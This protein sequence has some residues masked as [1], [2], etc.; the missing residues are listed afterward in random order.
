MPIGIIGMHR[1]GTSLV[2]RLLNVAGLFLG[3]ESALLPASEF[4]EAGHWEHISFIDINERLLSAFG[5]DWSDPPL[6]PAG[7]LQLDEVRLLLAEASEFVAE[8]FSAYQPWGWKDP[9]TTLVLPFWHELLPDTRWI[10]CVRNPLDVV[11]SLRRREHVEPSHVCALW[12]AYTELALIHTRPEN[13]LIIQYEDFFSGDRPDTL[14]Q[15]LKF[16][17]LDG[18][19]D[20]E[21]TVLT[22]DAVI[23]DDLRHHA[24]SFQQVVASPDVPVPTRLLY[25][26]LV[27]R[28]E[29]L[30]SLYAVAP[31]DQPTLHI[32]PI[33]ERDALHKWQ[34]LHALVAQSTRTEHES[35]DLRLQTAEKERVVQSLREQLAEKDRIHGQAATKYEDLIAS[36]EGEVS[37]R[38]DRL[39]AV[40][41]QLQQVREEST[42]QSAVDASTIEALRRDVDHRNESV[43]ALEARIVDLER[44]AGPL[45]ARAEVLMLRLE[46][47]AK[48]H[49]SLRTQ[50]AEQEQLAHNLRQQI[51]NWQEHWS[52]VQGTIGYRVIE[53]L[54]AARRRAIPSASVPEKLWFRWMR[55]SWKG[56]PSRDALAPDHPGENMTSEAGKSGNESYTSTGSAELAY[57]GVGND[58]LYARWIEE[59]EPAEDELTRQRDLSAGFVY[60]PLISII[61]P[62]YNP[63]PE[64]LRQAIES[65]REQTYDRWEL[66]LADGASDDPRVRQVLQ[67]CANDERIH[68][69]FLERNLGISG[70]SNVA[71]AQA[72]GDFVA[73][74][75][76]D[77]TLASDALFAVVEALNRDPE[78]D[79]I[80]S[81][82]D[83]LATDGRSRRA[84]LFK[85]DWSP[86]VMLSANYITHLTVLRTALVR[87]IG[88]FDENTDGAQDWDLFLRMAERTS[89][90][91]HLPRIL[92]HWRDSVGSTAVDIA[93][94]PYALDRQLGVIERHLSRVGVIDPHAFLDDS[95]F[96]RVRWTY[97]NTSLVSIIIPSRGASPMLERCVSSILE[98]TAYPNYEIVILNNGDELSD[99]FPY[100]RAISRDARVRVVQYHE[101]FNYSA[102]NNFGARQS[103]GSL[104][105]F[106]NNDTE[107]MAPDWLDE[108]AQWASLRLPDIGVVGAKLLKPD[109]TIQHAGVV[110]GLTGF[111]GHV[112][113]GSREAQWSI[114]GLAEWYR[115]YTAVTG[116]CMM[117]RRDV[118]DSIGG[119]DE[120]FVLCGSDVDICLRLRARGYE[121]VYDPFAKLR[122]IESAT[123]LGSI[124]PSDFV[125]SH[126]RYLPLLESGD[127]FFNPSLSYWNPKPALREGEERS[128]LEF[129]REFAAGLADVV[130]SRA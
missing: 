129:V 44:S 18:V 59:N 93:A 123:H 15:L 122:H 2:A 32:H 57:V 108:L 79:L 62:V 82:H 54:R 50:L 110:V 97:D 60:R 104:L 65:V 39:R 10:I 98:H 130:E 71:L 35:R 19:L 58:D 31:S 53:K 3:D 72:H 109:G 20:D 124:P 80:Y 64:A 94:K 43:T 56:R 27:H 7:W 126:D 9:R 70:N 40:H 16:V 47:E 86:A 68:I 67:E 85:P 55:S 101:S 14:A 88:G 34:S 77:D 33:I 6:L 12:Q 69:Q 105:L 37:D 115:N 29:K 75:D 8:T 4:N 92:Y 74:L 23:R 1:S 95:G 26:V 45:E 78:L 21:E 61:T 89:H 46:R 11:D 117:L 112:F 90:I 114:F 99:S 73:L 22:L 63:P 36:L 121:V 119:F 17:G 38:D 103:Q 25:D 118:F 52:L 5:G 100:Y 76:H 91:H 96:I 24:H 49:I 116:A 125:I 128:P 84:P 102:I 83:I 13:R 42:Q 48:T 51:G 111:A 28:P 81:D 106:L 107:I 127:P 66:C 87:E 120:A 41:A 30:D 113:A